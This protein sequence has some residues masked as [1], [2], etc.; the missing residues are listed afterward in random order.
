MASACAAAADRASSQGS[1]SGNATA[2][3]ALEAR[4]RRTLG[5]VRAPAAVQWLTTNEC[6]L[7]CAHCYDR[8]IPSAL[9]LGQANELLDDYEQFCA[10][11]EVGPNVILSGGNPFMYPKFYDVYRS[12]A[13]RG[14]PCGI[15]GG[16]QGG[17][18]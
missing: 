18:G 8:T 2:V 15:L 4:I 1:P 3:W 10:S 12:V 7:H 6:N 13:E 9:T 5:R 14:I 11:R 16:I 17:L